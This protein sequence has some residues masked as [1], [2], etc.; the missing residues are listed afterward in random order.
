MTIVKTF[1]IGILLFV[2]F[3]SYSQE[4]C[5]ETLTIAGNRLDKGKF[6]EIPDLLEECLNNGG[7]TKDE[8]IRAYRLLTLSQLYLDYRERAG[9]YYLKLL[10]LSP[11]YKPTPEVDPKELVN[12]SRLFT[13]KPLI[14]L[15][16]HFGATF[17]RPYV[18]MT[19]SMTSV[20]T[21][22]KK[23]TSNVGFEF[24]TGAEFLITGNWYIV[25]ELAFLSRS[26]RVSEAHFENNF[27][28][29]TIDVSQWEMALPVMLKYTFRFSKISPFASMGVSPRIVMG[30]KAKNQHGVFLDSNDET[31]PIKESP[32]INLSSTRTKL[33]Y[34]IV[35]G[36][37]INYKIGISYLTMEM[38]YTMDMFNTVD[39]VESTRLDLEGSRNIKFYSPVHAE[40][41]YRLTNLSVL[42]G[43][44]FPLYKPRKIKK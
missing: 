38:R 6:Y 3:P 24:A 21:G 20:G 31:Q 14:H 23:Y 16:A 28:E 18:L 12:F 7:F 30:A 40:D 32:D 5:S 2:V 44:N 9:V 29:S 39:V 13:T 43:Y 4:I 8:E 22:K 15:T 1:F 25:T 37:G 42:V 26:L 36:I 19:N 17:A 10:K 34:S 33:N 41:D 35:G 27:Y 11:E